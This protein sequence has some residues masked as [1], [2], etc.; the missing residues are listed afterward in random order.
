[1]TAIAQCTRCG[2]LSKLSG[3]QHTCPPRLAAVVPIQTTPAAPEPPRVAAHGRAAGRTGVAAVRV[4][5]GATYQPQWLRILR[6]ACDLVYEFTDSDLVVAVW[7]AY[8]DEFGLRGYESVH[9]SS[10]YV[11]SKLQ[12]ATG[13]IGRGFVAQI[14]THLFRVTERGRR[15]AERAAGLR[16]AEAK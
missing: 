6:V 4:Q 12:G 15:E 2:A 16:K 11:L 3:G 10:V 8:P 1:M 7:Q 9:P 5:N 14:E 13:L